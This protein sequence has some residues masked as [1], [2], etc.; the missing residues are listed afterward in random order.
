M[1]IAIILKN[2]RILFNFSIVYCKG[3]SA[4]SLDSTYRS[5]YPQYEEANSNRNH[6][7]S[8]H[9]LKTG[10]SEHIPMSSITQ[11]MIDYQYD[12]VKFKSVW[13]PKKG[14]LKKNKKLRLL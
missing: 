14:K 4:M 5:D 11:N 1:V 13:V 9:K 8:R 12:P 6:I 2:L 10:N 7:V 3:K